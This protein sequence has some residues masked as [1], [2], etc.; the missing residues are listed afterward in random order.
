MTTLITGFEPFEAWRQ[1]TS[2]LAVR[3]LAE[4]ALPS[5][6]TAVLPVSYTRAG[7]RVA[8]LLEAHRPST[9]ILLGL[10]GTAD[11]LRLER[12]ARNRDDS[13]RPD[14]DGV[15]GT[16]HAI[17]ASAPDTYPTTLPLAEMARAAEEL[18][19]RIEYSNDAG[20]YVC[21][22]TFFIAQHLTA[23]RFPT[24]RSGF[25]H[26]PD[27]ASNEAELA[28]LGSILKRWHERS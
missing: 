17:V 28:R 13:P 10:A 25:V 21:N 27:W 12:T 26:V 23:S 6:V 18:G 7:E 20:G 3:R 22:H 9:L 4:L 19:A 11:R 2:E 24:C 16:G 14:M 1:N 8:E 5:V 15:A